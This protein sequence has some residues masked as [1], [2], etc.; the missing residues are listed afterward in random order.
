MTTESVADEPLTTVPLEVRPSVEDLVTE[1]DTPM[2]NLFSEK[3]QRLL[4]E[5]LY[6]S[7]AGPGEGRAFLAMANVGLFY[8]VEQ[9]PYVPDVLLSLDVRCPAD[10]W[11]K[12]HRSYFL[13]EYGKPPDVVVEVVSNCKGGEDSDKLVGYA[14]I[15]VPYYAIFDP[16]NHLSD[17]VLRV[18]ELQRLDYRPLEEPI[19]LAGIG[20]G[21]CLWRGCYEEHENLWLRWVDASGQLLQ[22]GGERSEHAEQRAN[23]LAGQLRRLGVEPEA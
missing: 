19:L 17:E 11:P 12:S 14:R 21:L 10:L 7:W 3:Q 20:V 2:D 15:R 18:Y 23:K 5:P 6:T 9:P 22:T 1:D 13:W 8:A 4:T 16:E